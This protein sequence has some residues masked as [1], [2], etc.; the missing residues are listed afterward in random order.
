MG[1]TEKGNEIKILKH[2][3]NEGKEKDPKGQKSNPFREKHTYKRTYKQGYQHVAAVGAYEAV[4]NKKRNDCL[5]HKKCGE[6]ECV[7]D[8][9]G[10]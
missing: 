2:L 1:K 10:A 9:Q 5:G 4:T 6:Y 7:S 3:N 8:T